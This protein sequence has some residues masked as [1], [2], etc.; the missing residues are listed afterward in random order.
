MARICTDLSSTRDC[1]AYILLAAPGPFPGNKTITLKSIFDDI[2]AG[3]SAISERAK[4]PDAKELFGRCSSDLRSSY[5]LFKNGKVVEGQRKIREAKKLFDEAG[6][7]R[8]TKSPIKTDTGT[9]A[10]PFRQ[11]NSREVHLDCA[12]MT[13][14]IS[15]APA[16]IVKRFG[17]PRRGD[18]HKISGEYVFVSDS[19]GA[20]ILHD[21]LATSLYFSSGLTPDQFWAG[22]DLAELRVSSLDLDCTEFLEW[23]GNE[24]G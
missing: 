2:D 10:V 3:V 23:L 9:S 8:R 1:F 16:L 14:A 22:T 17:P 24:I 11:V 13:G 6:K 4:H 15:A 12:T 18:G 21:W 20:F 7:L 19:G 5:E